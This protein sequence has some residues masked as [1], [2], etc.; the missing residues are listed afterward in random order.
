MSQRWI[1]GYLYSLKWRKEMRRNIVILIF[2]EVLFCAAL[3]KTTISAL[4]TGS[5]ATIF[6]TFL[7]DLM[8]AAAFSFFG[9]AELI[10][11]R[12]R[13]AVYT[14]G[15]YTI[16]LQFWRECRRLPLDKGVIISQI[17]STEKL[18]GRNGYPKRFQWSNYF[19]LW[20]IGE[21]PPAS[22]E[23]VLAIVR[24]FSGIILPDTPEVR[25]YLQERLE[26]KEIPEY[27]RTA[28][29]SPSQQDPRWVEE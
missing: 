12:Q 11:S 22:E 21:K 13:N 28:I 10:L 1:E 24:Y 6:G 5:A 9:A 26:L 8:F 4:Q 15:E 29:Y 14:C 25:Q 18:P 7:V 3:V 17:K 23:S 2:L 19:A 27:P 16:S 20:A